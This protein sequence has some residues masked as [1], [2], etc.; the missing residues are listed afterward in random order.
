MAINFNV[1]ARQNPLK[2]EDA[3]KYYATINSK[4]KR[5][6]R[7]IAQRISD[8]STL[9]I[10]DVKAVLE[11]FLQVIP[12]EITDGYIVELEEFGNFFA[13]CTSK[14]SDNEEEV[15]SSNIEK[16]NLQFR[17]GRLVKEVLDR[18]Q[19]KKEVAAKATVQLQL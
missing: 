6:L 5:N 12:E 9:S 3:A 16:V 10:I 1:V 11:G 7:Y 2:R 4:G 17:P 19:F 18:A 15:N 13:T 8:K 14:S